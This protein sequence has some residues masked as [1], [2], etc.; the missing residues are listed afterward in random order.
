MYYEKQTTSLS[1]VRV[2]RE[3]HKSVV[4]MTL[5]LQNFNIEYR[6]IFIY[7]DMKLM[8]KMFVMGT[9]RNTNKDNIVYCKN[10]SMECPYPS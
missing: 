8:C 2:L 4:Q 7:Y 3:I 5:W 6:L 9:L 1:M 10:D